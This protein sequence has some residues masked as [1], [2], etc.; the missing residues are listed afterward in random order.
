MATSLVLEIVLSLAVVEC[1]ALETTMFALKDD[2]DWLQL[3]DPGTTNFLKAIT[4]GADNR[5]IGL[6]IRGV[7]HS[8][9]LAQEEDGMSV[10]RLCLGQ[11]EPAG[12]LQQL[13]DASCAF[14][15][16]AVFRVH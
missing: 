16:G 15:Q 1:N 3:H 8:A 9:C 5:L 4:G 7:A 12:G 2:F 14:E 6:G 11:R 10:R 13:T